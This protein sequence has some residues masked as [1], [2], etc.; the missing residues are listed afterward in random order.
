MGAVYLNMKLFFTNQNIYHG[1]LHANAA[2]TSILSIFA[3]SSLT[4]VMLFFQYDTQ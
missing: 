3:F 4:L 2:I 1:S